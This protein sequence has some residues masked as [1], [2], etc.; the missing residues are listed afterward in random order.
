MIETDG[1]TI[2]L[3]AGAVVADDEDDD[4]LDAA[5]A[6]ACGESLA[7]EASDADWFSVEA[8]T[9]TKVTVTIS[10]DAAGRVALVAT[11][12]PLS[13]DVLGEGGDDVAFTGDGEPIAV[14]L[15]PE[16]ADAGSYTIAV[17]CEQAG[18]KKATPVAG[19]WGCTQGSSASD[20]GPGLALL[21]LS[22]LRRRR[23]C[24]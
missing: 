7:L 16:D 14:G 10:G 17:A 21:A 20:V 23:R 11:R 24:R 4:T 8:P 6:M 13:R 15:V 5:T 19:A 9:G 1:R 3:E 22:V 12:G 2:S 18:E